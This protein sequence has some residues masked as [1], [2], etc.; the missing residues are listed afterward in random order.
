MNAVNMTEGAV[1][2]MLLLEIFLLRSSYADGG[3]FVHGDKV[4]KAPPGHHK[5]DLFGRMGRRAPVPEGYKGCHALHANCDIQP[6]SIPLGLIPLIYGSGV[7]LARPIPEGQ[8]DQ[9]PLWGTG[10]NFE[11]TCNERHPFVLLRGIVKGDSN[12]F[13]ERHCL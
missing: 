13:G 10:C 5:A 3:D 1:V 12:P 2:L 8:R 4:T 6:G 11:R 7:P 9:A